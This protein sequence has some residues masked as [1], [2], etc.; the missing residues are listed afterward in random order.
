MYSEANAK[1]KTFVISMDHHS[2]TS[3]EAKLE[4]LAK[5]AAATMPVPTYDES[6]NESTGSS[7]DAS[8]SDISN[9]QTPTFQTKHANDDVRLELR[10]AI[11]SR[12]V[13]KGL[14]E[15]PNLETKKPKIEQLSP[16]EEEK[17]RLRRERN[18]IAAW[19]CRQRR[20]E[21]MQQLTEESE[22]VMESN[23]SL[24]TEITALKAQKEQLE[25][26][27]KQHVP[28]NIRGTKINGDENT[29]PESCSSEAAK[30]VGSLTP[31]TPTKTN[32]IDSVA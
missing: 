18:K 25:K 32:P 15:M 29:S 20:K 31:T 3:Y 9:P 26:M 11:R 1:N 13:A 4:T 17:R 10:N 12:R 7:E 27:L 21:H 24:E 5:A 14:E 28:C 16:E 2:K 23:S 19:K 22:S 30:S 6:D 8:F